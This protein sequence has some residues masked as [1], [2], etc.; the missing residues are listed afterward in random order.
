MGDTGESPILESAGREGIGGDGRVVDRRGGEGKRG[1]ERGGEGRAGEGKGRE[2]RG[3]E[4]RER[5]EHGHSDEYTVT[6]IHVLSIIPH[7]HVTTKSYHQH[8]YIYVTTRTPTLHP[9]SKTVHLH[10]T[11]SP[12]PLPLPLTHISDLVEI[13]CLLYRSTISEEW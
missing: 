6:Y 1:E 8:T 10:T 12:L 13:F 3:G 7:I 2:G 5:S 9:T 4:G 11:S